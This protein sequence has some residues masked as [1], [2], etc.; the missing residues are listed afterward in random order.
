MRKW[1]STYWSYFQIW[2]WFYVF[3]MSCGLYNMLKNVCKMCD[4][5][6]CWTLQGFLAT[7]TS[8]NSM[9]YLNTLKQVR[10][11]FLDYSEKMCMRARKYKFTPAKVWL[12][13]TCFQSPLWCD[14]NCWLLQ[15]QLGPQLAEFQFGIDAVVWHSVTLF[16]K[17]GS[18]SSMGSYSELWAKFSGR[19]NVRYAW[20]ITKNNVWLR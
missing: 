10:T 13:S 19:K 4:F 14:T 6:P 1:S 7:W 3:I 20:C 2:G 5:A 16:E 12:V 18:K 8:R 17:L 9:T 11:R 15:Y